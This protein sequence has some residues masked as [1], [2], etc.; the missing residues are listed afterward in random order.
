MSLIY[1]VKDAAVVQTGLKISLVTL[2]NAE[3]TERLDTAED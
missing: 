1:D 2:K 3:T